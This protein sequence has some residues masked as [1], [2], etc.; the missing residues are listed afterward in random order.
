MKRDEENL[1][2]IPG[3]SYMFFERE[4]FLGEQR[5]IVYSYKR[6]RKSFWALRD[7]FLSEEEQK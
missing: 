3:I 7:F 2:F 6:S 4:Y 5:L 1:N